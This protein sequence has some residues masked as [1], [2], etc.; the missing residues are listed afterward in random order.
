MACQDVP[1]DRTAGGRGGL[2]L[3]GERPKRDPLRGRPLNF[4]SKPDVTYFVNVGCLIRQPN[5]FPLLMTFLIVWLELAG[6]L[7]NKTSMI[8]TTECR[9]ESTKL[10]PNVSNFKSS[11]RG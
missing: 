6:F 3:A 7:T 11:N 10:M 9:P 5:M 2:P 4:C 1:S 8:Q